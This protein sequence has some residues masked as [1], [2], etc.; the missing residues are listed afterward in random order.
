M[1]PGAHPKLNVS[2]DREPR[3]R[4]S[5]PACVAM[6]DRQHLDVQLVDLSSRGCKVRSNNG[7]HPG[8]EVLLCV[9]GKGQ[10]GCTVRWSRNG[11][12]GLEFDP[13]PVA[14]ER[15]QET[16][17][18]SRRIVSGTEVRLRR[19]GRP[20][21][22]VNLLDLSVDGCRLD[23]VERPQIGETVQLLFPGLAT[24]KAKIRWLDGFV[25]G[26]EF[27]Q[28][29]HPAVFELLVDRLTQGPT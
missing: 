12:A 19:V 18:S 28:P 15:K 7:L 5:L 10:L 2:S 4:L 22:Q 16:P 29:F 11:L 13:D 21:F 23:L 8:D 1:C 14:G 9:P 25:A 20:N 17:R 3:R 24:V 27:V 6:P 26:L